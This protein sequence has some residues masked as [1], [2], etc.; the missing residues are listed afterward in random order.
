VSETPQ[1]YCCVHR[2]VKGKA[3]PFVRPDKSQIWSIGLGVVEIVDGGLP[4]G[5][6]RTRAAWLHGE[7][8]AEV[9]LE[10]PAARAKTAGFG[11][12]SV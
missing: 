1:A 5:C 2:S 3:R 12:A 10:L 4:P 11:E 8:S 9:A 6:E 7:R